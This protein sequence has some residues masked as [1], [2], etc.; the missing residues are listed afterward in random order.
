M[1]WVEQ[2]KL[3]RLVDRRERASA[4]RCVDGSGATPRRD[5]RRQRKLKGLSQEE[6]S[7][8][9]D[10]KRSYVSDL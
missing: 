1:K 8:R 7:L 5:V 3:T 9:A 2:V 6:L 10:M 4:A